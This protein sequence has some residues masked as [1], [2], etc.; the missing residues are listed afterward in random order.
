MT[1]Y[2]LLILCHVVTTTSFIFL[3]ASSLHATH[4]TYIASVVYYSSTH[5]YIYIYASTRS[6]GSSLRS[7]DDVDAFDGSLYASFLPVDR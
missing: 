1:T 4:S 5:H 2:T 6:A 7:A 3:P